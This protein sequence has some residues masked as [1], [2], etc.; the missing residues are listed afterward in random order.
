MA[1]H[2][3]VV[4]LPDV[5]RPD[6]DALAEARQYLQRNGLV[7]E[8]DETPDEIWQAFDF[9]LAGEADRG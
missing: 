4:E 2:V 6:A 8:G 1:D 9:L 5:D 3:L 7:L